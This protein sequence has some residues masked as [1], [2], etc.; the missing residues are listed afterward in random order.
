MFKKNFLLL[1]LSALVYLSFFLGY[2][3]KENSAGGGF[4]DFKHIS[5][6]ILLFKDNNFFEID[7]T[8]Y[9]ST[10]LPIYYLIIKTLNIF[11]FF[12]IGLF[13]LFISLLTV[14]IFFRS[15]NLRLA[16]DNKCGLPHI[17]SAIL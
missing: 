14:L 1:S 2:L 15:L 16:T 6:N 7:W 13:N 8:K 5:N 9:E 4:I 12:K 11:D 17:V 3:L 10:S